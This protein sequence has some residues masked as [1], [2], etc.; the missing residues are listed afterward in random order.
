MDLTKKL[1]HKLKS[2]GIIFAGIGGVI[3]NEIDGALRDEPVTT[4]LV[5]KF[6]KGYIIKGYGH[7]TEND[8]LINKGR[9][10]INK[11]KSSQIIKQ[12]IIG[13]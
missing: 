10:Y 11:Y 4:Y 9:N 7:L 8:N 3:I 12:K 5:N 13:K 6:S 1:N 2:V